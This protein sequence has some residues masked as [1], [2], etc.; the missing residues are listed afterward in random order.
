MKNSEVIA[1][2]ILIELS[3]LKSSL[4]CAESCTGGSIMRVV[5]SAPGASNYFLGGVVAYANAVKVDHL[6]VNKK[7]LEKYGAVSEF[8]VC[9][10]AQGV[11]TQ[12]N[13]TYSVAT[14]GIS[15][16]AGGSIDK[17]VGLVWIAVCGPNN[18]WAKKFIFKNLLML[19]IF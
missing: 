19:K 17:P 6:L 3:R 12:L 5:T 1:E 2:K 14:T 16:P 15:G 11:R 13:S 8:T 9:A 4:A 7:Q 10:M 18:F